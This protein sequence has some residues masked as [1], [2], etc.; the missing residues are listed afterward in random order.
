MRDPASP[1]F[2]PPN[3][4]VPEERASLRQLVGLVLVLVAAG[5]LIGAVLLVINDRTLAGKRRDHQAAV[6][7]IAAITP[8]APAG[9]TIRI[10]D[11]DRA[12]AL[13]AE[14]HTGTSG[15]SKTARVHLDS[16]GG[17]ITRGTPC[18]QTA[19]A[20]V[21][22]LGR[23]AL[24]PVWPSAHITITSP[25][26]PTCTY[27]VVDTHTATR[28][29]GPHDPTVRAGHNGGLIGHAN[30]TTVYAQLDT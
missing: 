28:T 4:F 24:D 2:D 25:T 14:P 3:P 12:I 13:I 22:D 5:A 7:E 30:G 8:A 29:D 19:G 6:A 10:D 9:L 27:T 15:Y 18:S 11:I 1:Q 16:G 20:L 26:G 21:V 23:T 17:L